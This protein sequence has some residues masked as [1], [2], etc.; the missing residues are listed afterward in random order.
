MHP[1]ATSHHFCPPRSLTLPLSLEFGVSPAL[2]AKSVA[3]TNAYYGSDHPT[4]SRVL[5]VNG[6]VACDSLFVRS[7]T[8]TPVGQLPFDQHIR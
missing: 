6:E 5:W 8:Q 7:H 3:Q 2:V 1:R 4:G